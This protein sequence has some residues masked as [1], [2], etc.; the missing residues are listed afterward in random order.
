[1]K[2]VIVN[3]ADNYLGL[4]VASWTRIDSFQGAV[5]FATHRSDGWESKF[6][7]SLDTTQDYLRY[8]AQVHK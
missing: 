8:I 1:M 4:D 7:G 6:Q 2:I 3:K 5:A